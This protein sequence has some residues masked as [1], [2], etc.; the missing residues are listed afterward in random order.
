MKDH[1]IP[2][3]EA[4]DA[5][6]YKGSLTYFWTFW[7]N[8]CKVIFSLLFYVFHS[9]SVRSIT[10]RKKW[11]LFHIPTHGKIPFIAQAVR[12]QSECSEY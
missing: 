1:K 4:A 6:P 3:S 9:P 8:I 7:K 12:I 2:I 11:A 10:I 5:Y